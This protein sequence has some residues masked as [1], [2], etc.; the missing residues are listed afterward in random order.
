MRQ[1]IF[2]LLAIFVTTSGVADPEWLNTNMKE[3]DCAEVHWREQGM[4]Y[5]EYYNQRIER[6]NK[7]FHDEINDISSES[8]DK[9]D[10]LIA[11][12]NREKLWN[13]YAD[14]YCELQ[15]YC[16][17]GCGSGHSAAEHSCNSS[18]LKSRIDYLENEIINGLEIY[19]CP[20]S[21]VKKARVLSTENYEISLTSNCKLGLF[22]CQDITYEGKSKKSEDAITLTGTEYMEVDNEKDIAMPVGYIFQNNTIEYKVLK[23]GRLI[24]TNTQ[25]GKVLVDEKGVW[26]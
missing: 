19:G 16:T 25:N 6:I 12:N 8:C 26:N 2:I 11:F 4:C 15:N 13:Q 10:V 1:F 5:I 7:Y 20:I 21:G 17:R 3:S 9:N 22:L 18:M 14:S 23:S 24:V